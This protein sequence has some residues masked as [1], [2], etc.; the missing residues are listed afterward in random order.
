MLQNADLIRDIIQSLG[1][2]PEILL[3]IP[4]P[5][6]KNRRCLLLIPDSGRYECQICGRQGKLQQIATLARDRFEYRHRETV[7]LM[8]ERAAVGKVPGRR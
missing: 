1:C 2:K 3:R 6:C 4:C 7:R 5:F 8:G